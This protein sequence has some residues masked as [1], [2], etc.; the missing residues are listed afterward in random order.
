MSKDQQDSVKV[1]DS[2]QKQLREYNSEGN[3]KTFFIFNNN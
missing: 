2:I 1:D 3:F